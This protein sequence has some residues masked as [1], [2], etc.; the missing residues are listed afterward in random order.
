MNVPEPMRLQWGCR[1]VLVR[2]VCRFLLM[3]RSSG[4]RSSGAMQP[5]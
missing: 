4:R 1:L 2:V 3:I 5:R